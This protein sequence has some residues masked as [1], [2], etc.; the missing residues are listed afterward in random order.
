MAG[1]KYWV[2]GFPE[3]VEQ[4]DY[5]RNE[6]KPSELTSGSAIKVWWKCRLGPDHRWRAHPNNR[7]HGTGCPF[8][9]NRR[10]SVTNNLAVLYPSIAAEWHPENNGRIQPSEVVATSTRVAWWRCLRE[11]RHEWRTSVRDRTRELLGCPFCSNAR[12]CESNNLCVTHP[13]IAQEWHLTKNESLSPSEF[14]PG[15]SRCV[16][17][18]CQSCA[19][20]WRAR[21]ANRTSRASACPAC[22]G[23]HPARSS[24]RVLSRS[25]GS[26]PQ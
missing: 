21:I 24:S 18:R 25:D 12:A 19:N 20:E 9:A 11:S 14:T 7:T 3:L 8:C 16:W 5:E 26:L 17:W 1:S 15:S 4:W 10:A 2:D 6:A 13:K 22:A 23:P